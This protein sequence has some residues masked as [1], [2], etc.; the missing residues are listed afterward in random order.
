MTAAEAPQ[1]KCPQTGQSPLPAPFQ[2]ISGSS[3]LSKSVWPPR[4]HAVSLHGD[5]VSENCAGQKTLPAN[6]MQI[7][8]L[9]S[10]CLQL[11][12]SHSLLG[13]QFAFA[14]S[15]RNTS[16][17]MACIHL[18]CRQDS[19]SHQPTHPWP[20][21]SNPQRRTSRTS[22]DTVARYT[23]GSWTAAAETKRCSL[24]VTMGWACSQRGFL[25]RSL[26]RPSG[27]TQCQGKKPGGLTFQR[28]CAEKGW[29]TGAEQEL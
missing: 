18:A 19:P 29:S 23:K 3:S 1:P 2:P 10:A 14:T 26:G 28:C 9:F 11:A 24:P 22:P 25:A 16:R 4:P 7:A 12:A 27:R 13:P 17:L 21:P 8:C 6:S 15:R 5:P 20:W